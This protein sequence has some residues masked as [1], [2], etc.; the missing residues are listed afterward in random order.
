MRSAQS[1]TD[2][3]GTG[4]VLQCAPGFGGGIYWEMKGQRLGLA[5]GKK[6]EQKLPKGNC[7]YLGKE[8]NSW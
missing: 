7:A 5:F 1:V 6:E 3:G 4:E 8:I 2:G